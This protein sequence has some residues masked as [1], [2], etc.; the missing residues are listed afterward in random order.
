MT[1]YDERITTVSLETLRTVVEMMD[2]PVCLCGGWAV[3]FT[4]NEFFKE[5]KG[6]DYL[7]SQDIDIGFYL[8]PMISKSELGSSTLFKTLKVLRTNGFRPDGFRYRKEIGPDRSM[9]IST[10]P[11]PETF[12][13]YID[14]LVNSN[15]PSLYDIYPNCF[16]EAPLIEEVY[17]DERNRIPLTDISEDLFIPNR[18]ILTAM[19][20]RSLP[21]R[22]QEY[23]KM[24]KDLCDLYGLLW[25]SGRSVHDNLN[26]VLSF[27]DTGSLERA[28]SV[29]DDRIKADC[30][31]YLGE[32]KGSLDTILRIIDDHIS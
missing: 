29:V 10:A 25:F 12:S 15:P 31:R 32:P 2:H 6:R 3:Y 27:C 8:P 22:G 11:L 23:H 1:L 19:K 16:F 24:I 13:L 5:K 30:E 7:G 4:I 21:T 28:R 9:D 26:D 14:I 20:V 18:A 17:A